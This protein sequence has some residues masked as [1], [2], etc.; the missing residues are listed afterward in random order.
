MNSYKWFREERI[1]NKSTSII[2]K[3]CLAILPLLANNLW[4]DDTDIFLDQLALPAE[5]IRPNVVFILDTSGSMGLPIDTSIGKGNEKNNYAS[6]TNYPGDD[7]FSGGAG[8]D[9]YYYLYLKPNT[10]A[11]QFIFYNKVHKDQMLCNMNTV[12]DTTPYKGGNDTYVYETGPTTWFSGGTSSQDMCAEHEASCSFIA[13]SAGAKVDCKSEQNEISGDGEYPSSNRNNYLT[14][15]SANYH[16]YLQA[17]Y[18]Y[19]VL[20][21]V[22]K[23]MVDADYDI[24]F[25]LMRFRGGSGG[26]VFQESI[27]A[28]DSTDVSDA[29]QQTIRDSLDDIFEFDDSTPLTEALWEGYRYLAGLTADYGVGHNAAAAY[30]SGTTYN[31]PIDYS[32]QQSHVVLLT[33]G[34][35]TSDTGRNTQIQGASYTNANCSGNCLDEFAQWV[36]NDGNNIRDHS[37]LIGTQ[38][39]TI[40]TVGLGNA[41]DATLLAETAANGG[42][43]V[44][45]ATTS[46]QLAIAFSSI[47]DQATFEKD[48][49]VAPA[50]AVN[51]YS[52]L[53][54]R[55]ELYF[56]LFKP[57]S[58]PRWSG[59]LKKYKLVDGEIR[60]TSDTTAID[61]STGYFA[62][63]SNSYWTTPRDTNGDGSANFIVDGAE[64][65]LG[66]MATQLSTPTSRKMYT[67]TGSAP[68]YGNSPPTPVNLI[69]EH[70]FLDTV[71]SGDDRNN[72]SINTT[73]TLLGNTVTTPAIAEEVINWIRGGTADYGSD[74]ANAPN[75]FVADGIHNP[76]VV[77]TYATDE[78]CVTTAKTND[79]SDT[80]CF[81]D[82][83]YFGTNLGTL[84]AI[85]AANGNEVF[86]FVPKELLPNLSLYYNATGGFNAKEYGLDGAMSIW[87]HDDDGDGTIESGDFV[88]LYQ[89][90]RR[91]GQNLYAFDL[92]D[93][94]VPKMIWQIDGSA[95]DTTPAGDY[96]DLA[97][98]WSAPQRNGI[99]WCS[100]GSC[101]ER[102]VLFFGGGYDPVHDTATSPQTS[103]KGNAIYMVDATTGELLWSAGNGNHHDF[104]NS[105]LS[106]SFVA[107]VTTADADGDGL[108]DFLFAIDIQGKLWRFDFDNNGTIAG[109]LVAEFGGSGNNFRR[110]FNAPDVAYFAPRG[111]SPFLT[112][113]VASG[114]RPDPKNED[115][116]DRLYVIFDSNALISPSSYSYASGSTIDESELGAA[117]SPS[118]YGWFLALTGTG[119]KGLSSTVTFN[120]K[121]VMTT[122]LPISI[123]SCDGST[124]SGRYYFLDAL[125][126][127]STLV[128][129]NNTPN[130]RTDDSNINFK[131]LIHG[132]I[133]PKPALI[134]GS[135]ET[136]IN[137]CDA[138]DDDDKVIQKQTTVTT[139]IGTEC[140]DD[141]IGFTM[142]KEYW[143]EN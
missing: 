20:L 41:T 2:S 48:T 1:M 124:G 33:D 6:A 132:G 81:D 43:N 4:A 116:N 137:N 122:F 46:D 99:N 29:N 61:D 10:Y 3:L 66:G 54:H 97:Q 117:G 14:V 28:E 141:D 112:I 22:M 111:K 91:G 21:T 51:A 133:P 127:S 108:I 58:S 104:N 118:A 16:N 30:D 26:Y 107:D 55:E 126:G 128:D 114:L 35:P 69:N 109:G 12:E 13:E 136:C 106:N 90:M 65:E 40:H 23:E 75:F 78:G 130:D 72:S 62:S 96:R 125:T 101:A 70:L 80:A 34:A 83:V 76:P 44:Y 85:D 131:S 42:G 113:S 93:R 63:K 59:N 9:N 7:N 98:T 120:E 129:D 92:T 37:A 88:Y 74:L 47:L 8:D 60:D 102:E 110:F 56:A 11:D 134:Y 119:E 84:H 87:R 77:V 86:S 71:D 18:R 79:T 94:E 138:A 39:I 49:F 52:G 15:V 100:G 38:E 142:N 27:L 50:V 19:T 36:R 123:S 68:Y 139:C 135:K 25:S 67:Y 53:Q 115:I 140:L 143:R 89:P 45:S 121:I 31:S 24:N 32:C 105:N 73:P 57:D 103:S 64:I 5:Q 82:V 95:L 17:Y